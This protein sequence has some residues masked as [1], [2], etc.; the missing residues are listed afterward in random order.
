MMIAS[1]PPPLPPTANSTGLAEAGALC[2]GT[3]PDLQGYMEV[4]EDLGPIPDSVHFLV[5]AAS[6]I[7]VAGA[8]GYYAKHQRRKTRIRGV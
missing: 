5:I 4:R 3:S 1:F 6:A 7:L 8:A 2:P